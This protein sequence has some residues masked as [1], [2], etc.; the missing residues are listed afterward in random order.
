MLRFSLLTLLGVVL[1]AGIGSAALAN[2]T[3]AWRQVVVTGTVAVLSVTTLAAVA[4]RPASPFARGFAVM[5]WAYL[6][7]TFSGVFGVREHLLSERMAGWLFQLVHDEYGT[8]G[9]RAWSSPLWRLNVGSGSQ[10]AF[11]PP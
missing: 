8:S 4:K 6:V 3:D 11:V 2:P 1:V 9:A 10:L 7:L 5:G